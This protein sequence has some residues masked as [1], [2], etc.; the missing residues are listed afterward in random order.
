MNYDVFFVSSDAAHSLLCDPTIRFYTIPL[1]NEA[2]VNNTA[3][4]KANVTQLNATYSRHSQHTHVYL[5]FHCF[6]VLQRGRRYTIR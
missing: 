2:I 5:S 4:A 6:T 3:L 1:S